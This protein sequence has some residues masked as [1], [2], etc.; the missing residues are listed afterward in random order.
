[1]LSIL[2]IYTTDK[3]IIDK[4]LQC[5]YRYTVIGTLTWVIQYINQITVV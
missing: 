5:M 1:M 4:I 2:D 3:S